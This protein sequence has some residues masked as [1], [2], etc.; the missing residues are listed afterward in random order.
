MGEKLI[1]RGFR[2]AASK[3][4]PD[5][6]LVGNRDVKAVAEKKGSHAS[7]LSSSHIIELLTDR[8]NSDAIMK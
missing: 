2:V 6:S 3:C 7:R 5:L 8:F 4:C 1:G